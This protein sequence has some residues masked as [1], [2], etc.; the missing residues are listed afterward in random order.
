VCAGTIR[1]QW[2]QGRRFSVWVALAAFGILGMAYVLYDNLFPI[3]DFPLSLIVYLFVGLTAAI[4]VAYFVLRSRR[5][6][7]LANIGG[8]VEDEP[9]AAVAPDVT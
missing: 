1:Y 9:E 6:E 4:C 2:K 5:P 3:P 7:V 8:T